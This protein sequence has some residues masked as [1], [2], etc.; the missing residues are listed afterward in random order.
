MGGDGQSREFPW[1]W[2]RLFVP[3]KTPTLGGHGE[4]NSHTG[5]MPCGIDGIDVQGVRVHDTT[6]TT[7][8]VVKK[9]VIRRNPWRE[10]TEG[11]PGEK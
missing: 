2:L 4:N 11:Y 1:H 6:V 8:I 10:Q 7:D 9:E 5:W 3:A